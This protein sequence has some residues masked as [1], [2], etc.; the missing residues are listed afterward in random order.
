MPWVRLCDIPDAPEEGRLDAYRV[1]RTPVA[2]LR[3]DGELRAYLNLC[4]H[5]YG[6][7]NAECL[8]DGI[9]TCPLHHARF[10]A[11][12]GR[13]LA[14]PA[15]ERLGRLS[16]AEREGIVEVLVPRPLLEPGVI[17]KLV[18]RITR[19]RAPGWPTVKKM[20]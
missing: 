2:L 19:N 1:G 16:L 3:H 20:G 5:A 10:D 12:D 4:T 7:F 17:G 15:K 11:T 18:A 9:L 13:V 6:T 14:G 8:K